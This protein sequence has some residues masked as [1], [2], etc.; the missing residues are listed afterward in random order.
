MY[1]PRRVPVPLKEQLKAKLDSLVAQ[2]IIEPVTTPT[3]WISNIVVNK[4]PG[5]LRV[6][7]DPRDL[8]KAICRPKYQMP[9]LDEILPALANAQ[10]FSILAAK[11]GFHQVKLDEESSYLTTFWSPYGQYR[12][13]RMPFGISSAPEEFQRRMHMICQDLPGVVVIADDILVYGCGSTEEYRK[14]HDANLKRQMDRAREANLKLNRHKLRLWLS[15][16]MYMGH[17]LTAQGVSPDPNK[18][19][20]IV[21]IPRP[22]DKKGV[23]RLLSC[24]TY[25]SRF[26]PKLSDVVSLLR[27][28]TERDVTFAWLTDQEQAFNTVKQMITTAPVLRYYDVTE[29]VTVQSDA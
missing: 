11:D 20:I 13:V 21:N 9:I 2:G 29:E 26:L 4:R 15:E 5:K 1:V 3:P 25:L 14:D 12:Y 23:E 18:V 17:W 16:V 10:L 6:C 24:V 27:L 8:N 28:L 22:V 7:I 19:N